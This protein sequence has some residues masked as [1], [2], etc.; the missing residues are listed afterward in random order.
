MKVRY[1]HIEKI[2][3][4]LYEEHE[5]LSGLPV[6]IESLI[7]RMGIHFVEEA[8]GDSLSGAAMIDGSRKIIS[9][10]KAHSGRRKRF[11]MAHELGHILLHEDQS[12]SVDVK[13]ITFLRDDVASTGQEWREIEA[14]FFAASILMPRS[15]VQSELR[16]L[17]KKI[18]DEDDLIEALAKKF[19]VSPQAM[20]IRLGAI[21]VT[22][23]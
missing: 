2:L 6:D 19:D 15:L 17:Q 20:G 9:V 3:K 14:N 4:R 10:N 21:G 1:N 23:L 7:E 5:D 18:I 12:L 22:A 8:F 13:P 11:T 16:K